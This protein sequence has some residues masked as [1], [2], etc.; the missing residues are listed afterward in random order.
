M[1]GRRDRLGAFFEDDG[2]SFRVRRQ[3]QLA[4]QSKPRKNWFIIIS[5]LILAIP[6]A[7]LVDLLI[8]AAL[9]GAFG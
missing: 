5:F 3:R 1:R 6:A 4:A 8:F 7:A 2:V 9:K